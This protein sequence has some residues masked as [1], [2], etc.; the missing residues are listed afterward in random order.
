MTATGLVRFG[1]RATLTTIVTT[2]LSRQVRSCHYFS[3]TLNTILSSDCRTLTAE[4][5]MRITR[6]KSRSAFWQ[7]VHAAGVPHIR[8]N[9]RNIIFDAQAVNDWLN[10]RSSATPTP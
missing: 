8:L 4:E 10:A 2:I 6:H 7:F 5:V 9:A 3:H 1:F